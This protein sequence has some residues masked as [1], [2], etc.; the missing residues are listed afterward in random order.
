M[1][2]GPWPRRV[3][4]RP[5]GSAAAAGAPGS[6]SRR[7]RPGARV[8]PVD[9]WVLGWLTRTADSLVGQAPAV[10]AELLARAVASSRPASRRDRLAARLADALYRIGDVAQAEQVASQALAHAAEPDIVVD[11]HWT[12]AQCRMVAGTSAESLATLDQALAAPGHLGPA[13]R[14]AAGAR[15]ADAPRPRRGR[16]GG[17]GRRQ[18]AGGG[19]GGGRQLGHGLGAARADADDRGAGRHARTPCRCST[20]RWP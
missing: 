2:G 11:L 14:P 18:R 19:H 17:P 1:P 7:T 13:P 12:L 16:P 8:E 3:P 9:E 15:R 6:R 20:G 4:R 5:G 10:A